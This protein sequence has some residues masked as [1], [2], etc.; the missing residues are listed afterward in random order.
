MFFL[1]LYNK[2]KRAWEY[3]I[4]P[5]KYYAEKYAKKYAKEYVDSYHNDIDNTSAT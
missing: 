3:I 4:Y 1:T 5:S 2:L